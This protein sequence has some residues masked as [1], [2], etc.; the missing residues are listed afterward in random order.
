M[1]GTYTT[2]GAA[3]GDGNYIIVSSANSFDGYYKFKLDDLAA[4]K[5]EG[6]DTQYNA[7]DLANG[8]L[9]FQKE[10]DAKRDLNIPSL[11]PLAPITSDARIFP[12][13]VTANEF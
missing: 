8:N 2:N 1:P 7:S 11:A 3:V 9:L 12:N 13:P 4:V 10:A 6:S 5:V